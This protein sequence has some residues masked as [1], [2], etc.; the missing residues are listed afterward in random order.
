[1]DNKFDVDT[2][3]EQFRVIG[4]DDELNCENISHILYVALLNKFRIEFTTDEYYY[5]KEYQERMFD[6][7]E[8]LRER[9]TSTIPIVFDYLS[10]KNNYLVD[11]II[12]LW[13]LPRTDKFISKN[14]YRKVYKENIEKYHW[15]L[16]RCAECQFMKN[17][18]IETFSKSNSVSVH[19]I[20]YVW[21]HLNHLSLEISFIN[22]INGNYIDIV[23][24]ESG[25]YCI[26]LCMEYLLF[27]GLAQ[28][29]DSIKGSLRN[30]L[31]EFVVNI[32]IVRKLKTNR[33]YFHQ[34]KNIIKD[35]A[36]YFGEVLTSIPEEVMKEIE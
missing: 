25:N 20:D 8:D 1:M 10:N 31:K 22:S 13:C 33:N 23:L 26:G 27:L 2:Y 14:I 18:F 4:K 12:I 36:K 28:V 9:D 16:I 19:C 3:L 7:V 30:F 5:L 11:I 35:P 15:K 24:D 34:I 32:D 6:L 17:F 21:A 29:N